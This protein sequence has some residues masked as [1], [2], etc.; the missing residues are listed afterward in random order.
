[1]E[2]PGELVLSSSEYVLCSSFFASN[3]KEK[4]N[5]FVVSMAT[6]LEDWK[7]KGNSS[8]CSMYSAAHEMTGL[9]YT[10]MILEENGACDF[11]Y[12]GH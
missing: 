8:R 12:V 10:R 3:H 9:P 4:D 1:M 2:V 6:A 7:N 5:S 11:N